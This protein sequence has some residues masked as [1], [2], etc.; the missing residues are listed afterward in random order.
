MFIPFYYNGVDRVDNQ[1]GYTVNIIVP[2]CKRC[3]VANSDLTLEEFYSWVQEIYGCL[4][5]KEEI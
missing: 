5:G 4:V 2:C 1:K 3:N